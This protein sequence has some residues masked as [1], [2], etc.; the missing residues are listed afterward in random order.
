M[1]DPIRPVEQ[2]MRLQKIKLVLRVLVAG[3]DLALRERHKALG[4]RERLLARHQAERE[5][6]TVLAKALD[7]GPWQSAPH[8]SLPGRQ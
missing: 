4:D 8:R 6:E 3:R 2:E 1:A 5:P 7:G